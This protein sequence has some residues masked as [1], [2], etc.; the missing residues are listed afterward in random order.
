MKKKALA[1]K[2]QTPN[3]NKKCQ[4]QQI[5]Q[6][7]SLCHYILH[8]AHHSPPSSKSQCITMFCPSPSL[9]SLLLRHHHLAKT[10]HHQIQRLRSPRNVNK[11]SSQRLHGS[12]CVNKC[13][14]PR[15][16]NKRSS[17]RKL[18]KRSEVRGQAVTRICLCQRRVMGRCSRLDGG[19]RQARILALVWSVARP[20]YSNCPVGRASSRE[21]CPG[22]EL[23]RRVGD[24]L[25][26]NELAPL[27]M[28]FLMDLKWSKQRS[29]MSPCA[30]H[31]RGSVCSG[32]MLSDLSIHRHAWCKHACSV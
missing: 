25:E 9:R 15:C 18:K 27:K 1:Q 13:S 16:V 23:W 4:T 10:C 6:Q 19:E 29:C 32:R 31:S 28:A 20:S 7:E 2:S 11:C 5:S 22:L 30:D 14:S 21:H 12:R 24:D 3:P 8:C 26:E 17:Q